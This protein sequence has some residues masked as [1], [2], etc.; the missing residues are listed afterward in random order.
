MFKRFWVSVIFSSLVLVAPAQG[1]TPEFDSL[2]W[3]KQQCLDVRAKVLGGKTY[4]EILNSGNAALKEQVEGGFKGNSAN[5]TGGQGMAE[6]GR[7]LPSSI[8]KTEIAFG[9]KTTFTDIG[10]F[11]K[12]NYTYALMIAGILSVIMIIVAGF[13]WVTSGGNSESISSAKN[14]I[15]GALIGLFIA[16]SSFFILNTINPALVNMRLPQ[17]WMIRP[18]ALVPQFCAQAA[19]TYTFAKA[20]SEA[21]QVGVLT[22][23]GS[24]KYD[25]KFADVRN[26]NFN[27][28]SRFFLKNGNEGSDKTCF[29]N[30]C[31]VGSS[32][33]A[34][35]KDDAQVKNN[36]KMKYGCKSGQLFVRYQ[37]TALQEIG[38]Q[39]FSGG[40]A[41]DLTSPDWLDDDSDVF[42]PVCKNLTINELSTGKSF[43]GLQS[44]VTVL[45]SNPFNSYDVIYKGFENHA[46]DCFSGK[47]V[48]FVHKIELNVKYNVFKDANWNIGNNGVSGQWNE[49]VTVSNYIPYEDLL[50]GG[51][52]ITASLDGRQ[53]QKLISVKG[54]SPQ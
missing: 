51:V 8:T 1:S 31:G 3:Q 49:D 29:G 21:D 23:P 40:W 15:S 12:S 25:L 32:C 52:S 28:G 47:L 38:A 41:G 50:N 7:C 5:C 17:A 30:V 9:G 46:G 44:G 19:P 45:P 39:T 16:Y 6:W 4:E 18:Q 20:G 53:I 11:L 26:N 27:C 54:S 37:V 14:R 33:V 34:L 22:P 10:D 13:Q 43:S 24:I 35:A 42:W 2:C 48:G 36:P